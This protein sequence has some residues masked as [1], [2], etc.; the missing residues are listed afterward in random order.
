MISSF[1][2][3]SAKLWVMPAN[4][5]KIERK[6]VVCNHVNFNGNIANAAVIAA[7]VKAEIK[8]PIADFYRELFKIFRHYLQTVKRCEVS[9][10]PRR[11]FGF[12]IWDCHHP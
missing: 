9:F 10:A 1:G 5:E 2:K 8:N 6:A 7:S 11:K 12:L 4:S 3:L